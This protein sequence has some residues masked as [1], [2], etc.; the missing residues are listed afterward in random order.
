[1]LGEYI[2]VTPHTPNVNEKMYLKKTNK[3]TSSFLISHS[4]LSGFVFL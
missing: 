1:M 3:Q 4:F 2:Y